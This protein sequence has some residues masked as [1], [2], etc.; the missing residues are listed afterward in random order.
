M[1]TFNFN[2]GVNAYRVIDFP[3]E[4]HKKVGN[5]IQSNG[6]LVI[7][8]DCDAPQN[9]T[10]MF[11]CDNPDLPESKNPNILVVPVFNTSMCSKYAYFIIPENNQ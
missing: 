5:V 3:F 1:N 6:T 9:A 2:T 10:L 11:L 7:P 8:F 4:Y